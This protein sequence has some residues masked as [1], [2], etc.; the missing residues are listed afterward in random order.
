LQAAAVSPAG[1]ALEESLQRVVSRE[2]EQF[3]TK[4]QELER[5]LTESL[6]THAAAPGGL[7]KAL[8]EAAANWEAERL[9]LEL[10][11]EEEHQEFVH[12][13]EQQLEEQR[14]RAAAE[15]QRLKELMEADQAHFNQERGKLENEITRL[16]SDAEALRQERDRLAVDG[17]TQQQTLEQALAEE[18][19]RTKADR[20]RWQEEREAFQRQF[21][22]ERGILAG[23]IARL[24]EEAE[25]LRQERDRHAADRAESDTTRQ[26]ETA[27][28][29][30][31]IDRLGQAL[32]QAQRREEDTARH[33]RE[34]TEKLR[35]L[36]ALCDQLGSQGHE[37]RG[38]LAEMERALEVARAAA[39]MEQ[40][41][42]KLALADEQT[43]NATEPQKW[44]AELA[45]AQEQFAQDRSALGHE[46]E[47]LTQELAGQ[48]H[49]LETAQQQLEAAAQQHQAVTQELERLQSQCDAAAVQQTEL[50]A[51][52]QESEASR[53]HA[54]AERQRIML[55]LTQQQALA[56]DERKKWQDEGDAAR[57]QLD[58]DRATLQ[59]AIDFLR[60]QSAGLQQERDAALGELR[61]L[62]E[63]WSNLVSQRGQLDS[64]RKQKEQRSHDELL[65][66]KQALEQAVQK[67]EA[68]SRHNLELTELVRTLKGRSAPDSSEVQKEKEAVGAE[69]DR[70]EKA[71][72]DEQKRFEGDRQK[73]R[74]E[75][76]EAQRQFDQDR[77][78]LEAA[79]AWARQETVHF[80][81]VLRTMG[82]TGL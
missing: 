47:R 43:R 74:A 75:M 41:K 6:G 55:A 19:A 14:A 38:R 70:L 32:Q 40:E 45:A 20:Q 48:K 79:A 72:A 66:L 18:K 54:K 5:S 58:Q 36:E 65:R 17:A 51:L 37:Q 16:R 56:A 12:E 50:A 9:A 11:W 77:A 31:E 80:R 30:A 29:Q 35:S 24:R 33:S 13:A 62:N 1:L 57:R 2:G 4:N 64:V 10:Q 21:S 69:R 71:L 44:Q 67:E 28:A 46:V 26:K 81:Q 61:A 73:W 7:A 27:Q 23:E 25:T 68:T 39:T 78:A 8:R 60:K 49:E 53:A 3:Q 15:W 34:M 59:N 76:E 22:E 82:V 42:L 63:E 52:R